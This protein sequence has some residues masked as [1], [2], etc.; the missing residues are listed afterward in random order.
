[1]A[2]SAPHE[3]EMCNL[4]LTA[5]TGFSCTIAICQIPGHNVTPT[6]GVDI[7]SSFQGRELGIA[8]RE[9]WLASIVLP[10]MSNSTSLTVTIHSVT[11]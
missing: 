6:V 2:V 8:D 4:A 7:E 11:T 5:G 9:A 10:F 1:M 3:I